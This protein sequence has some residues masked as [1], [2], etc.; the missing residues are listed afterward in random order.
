MHSLPRIA[1][2]V[3]QITQVGMRVLVKS[4]ATGGKKLAKSK[5][6]KPAAPVVIVVE[7]AAV[8]AAAADDD[9]GDDS[10]DAEQR[11]LWYR[12]IGN[13]HEALGG[14]VNAQ[15]A[16]DFTPVLPVPKSVWRVRSSATR[17][18]HFIKLSQKIQPNVCDLAHIYLYIPVHARSYFTAGLRPSPSS[19]GGSSSSSPR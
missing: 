4:K 16:F 3:M 6:A 15:F 14:S 5:T 10:Q 13:L 19:S 9:G 7:P 17:M 2:A 18:Q 12:P 8:A 1:K 11:L